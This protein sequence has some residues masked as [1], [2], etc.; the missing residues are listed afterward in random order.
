MLF[1]KCCMI[2]RTLVLYFRC[3]NFSAVSF[4]QS[5]FFLTLTLA[6]CI[7]VSLCL[8][9]FKL[10]SFSSACLRSVK[11]TAINTDTSTVVS[12]S[13]SIWSNGKT[14]AKAPIPAETLLDYVGN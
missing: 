12:I 13:C 1:M 2:V 6:L 7:A 8:H 4:L 5:S 10:R 9:L 11:A 14:L 3:D